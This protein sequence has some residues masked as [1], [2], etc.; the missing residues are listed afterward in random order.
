MA[1]ADEF[2]LIARHW[3]PLAKEPGAFGL[4][5]DAALLP[6]L[7]PG[8]RWVAAADALV[9]RVHYLPDDPPESVGAKLLRVNL[10]DLAAM[11]AEPRACLVTLA[12][13]Q[14]LDEAWLARFAAGLSGDLEAF[15]VALLGGDTV[16]TPGPAAL[17]L[18]ILGAAR[19]EALLRRRGALPGD[20]LLVSGPLG[21]AR[22]GLLILR[23]GLDLR[24]PALAEQAI[25]AFRRPEP[26]LALGRRLAGSGLVSAGMDLSDGLIGDAGHLAAAA[27]LA[28]VIRLAAL[29]LAAPT[30]QALALGLMERR[31]LAAGGDD[32]ELLIA[33][34]AGSLEALGSPLSEVGCF[35]AGEG[36]WLETPE[37]QRLR[38]EGGSW[39]HF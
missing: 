29:P 12:L 21:L 14:P 32:Y 28:V 33:A 39:R 1:P 23:D 3:A 31:D 24:A 34:P 5:D 10:S 4:G 2:G 38:S 35:E 20:R 18:T 7:A 30:R 16:S 27:G 22:L 11:G 9:E 26:R 17:S 37:G 19:P 8:E 13:P 25:A 6:E 15:G 36:V